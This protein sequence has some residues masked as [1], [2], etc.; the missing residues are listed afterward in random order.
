MMCFKLRYAKFKHLS[1]Q[2]YVKDKND[3]FSWSSVHKF[4]FSKSLSGL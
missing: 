4:F 1:H 2:R 3:Y